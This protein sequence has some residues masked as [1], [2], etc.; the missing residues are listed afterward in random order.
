MRRKRRWK[1]EAL[2]EA[3]RHSTLHIYTCSSVEVRRLTPSWMD[4]ILG[5]SVPALL[6]LAMLALQS[7]E[8]RAFVEKLYFEY[9]GLMYAVARKYFGNRPSDM[10]DAIAA[11]LENMCAYV[12]DFRAVE[13]SN[14]HNYVLATIGNICR[15]QVMAMNKRDSLIDYAATA[16]R[17]DSI[18]DPDD[19]Y[20]SIFDHADAEALLASMDALSEREKDLIRMRHVDGMTFSEMA[21]LLCTSEGAVRT[22][23]TRA[24]QRVRKMAAERGKRDHASKA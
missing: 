24:K 5:C 3:I 2:Y 9:R 7:D 10:E 11:A 6:P 8:D 17:T 15:R 21:K 19:A 13:Q 22:A 14:L 12:E 20:A 1:N 4:Q 23:L 16:E 18:P